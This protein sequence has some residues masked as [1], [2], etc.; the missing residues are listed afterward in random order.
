METTFDKYGDLE[1]VKS[2]FAKT[3]TEYVDDKTVR[4]Y[5]SAFSH[6]EYLSH[7]SLPNCSSLCSYAFAYCPNLSDIRLDNIRYGAIYNNTGAIGESAFLGT[8]ISN[9][10]F[11]ADKIDRIGNYWFS[12][13]NNLNDIDYS[14]ITYIGYGIVNG[15]QNLRRIN[16]PGVVDCGNYTINNCP[17]LTEV[18]MPNLPYIAQYMFQSCTALQE[19][20]LG[21]PTS[22]ISNAAFSMCTSLEKLYVRNDSCYLAAS[23][24][25]YSTK[26][27]FATGTIYVPASRVDYYKGSTNWQWF[28]TQIKGYDYEN[29]RPVD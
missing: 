6:N 21:A 18:N 24:V 22:Q 29:D 15:C 26:I 17:A 1:V 13:C 9:I 8:G 16:L 14:H 23:S 27:T 19:M 28:S 4:I 2:F 12:G 7:V 5:T 20:S 10:D 25:F 3:L 11:L